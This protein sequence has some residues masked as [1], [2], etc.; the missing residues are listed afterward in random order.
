M[1]IPRSKRRIKR[2]INMLEVIGKYETAKILTK[3]AEEIVKPIYNY[4]AK[5]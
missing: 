5:S 2:N 4:K 1:E 3:Q